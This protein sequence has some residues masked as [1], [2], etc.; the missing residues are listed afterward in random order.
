MSFNVRLEALNQCESTAEIYELLLKRGI[1][2][3]RRECTVCPIAVYLAGD[4]MNGKRVSVETGWER[5]VAYPG[6]ANRQRLYAYIYPYQ[7]LGVE[8]N[9]YQLSRVVE[10]FVDQF[11]N[12]FYP[13]LE[14]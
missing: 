9:R 7:G 4:D 1:R 13:D 8:V 3:E 5:S 6:S 2:G 14:L 12:G 10:D 11:D